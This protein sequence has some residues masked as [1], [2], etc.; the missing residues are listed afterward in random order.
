MHYCLF[1]VESNIDVSQGL[2]LSTLVKSNRQSQAAVQ[3]D[4][5]TSRCDVGRSYR[6][7]KDYDQKHPSES[8]G[9]SAI[10]AIRGRASGSSWP[11]QTS[12]YLFGTKSFFSFCKAT[13]CN[14]LFCQRKK[15]AVIPKTT[16]YTVYVY[17]TDKMFCL[18]LFGF[19]RTLFNT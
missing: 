18:S 10:V 5:S 17:A 3:P 1:T 4:I 8:T 6:G 12:Q 15:I 16:Y 14:L 13:C 7:R 2:R 19:T 9:T 11:S